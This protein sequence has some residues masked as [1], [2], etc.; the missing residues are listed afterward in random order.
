MGQLARDERVSAA[1][2]SALRRSGLSLPEKLR[3]LNWPIVALLALIGAVGY[4]MLYSAAGGSLAPWAW[5]HAVRLAVLLPTMVLAALID[6]RVW[7]RA[8]WPFYVAVLAMLVAVDVLGEINKGAQ[9]WLDLGPVQLQPSELMKVALI[10]VL[11]RYFHAVYPEDM[12]RLRVLLPAVGLILTPCALVLVQPDLGTAATLLVSG[13]AMLFLAGVRWW[14]F[15][16]VGTVG[17]AALPV[18]WA[19]L[20]DYQRQ[21]VFTFLDPD[22]DPLG[23]GYHIIQSKIA[24]GSGGMWGRGFLNGS[25]A[26]L[27]FLPEKHT[28]FAFTMLAEELGFVGA[29]SVLALFLALLLLGM[30]AAIRAPS[31]FGRLLAAGVVINLF[32]YIAINVS[33][34]TGLIPVVGVPLPLISYG[35]TALLTVLVSLGLLLSVDLHHH[36]AIP[37]YPVE[38]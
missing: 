14:K 17:A 27:S 8:A 5:R 7:F 30:V 16:A 38:P 13:T 31:Q 22:S 3:A 6:P 1:L 33:M 29:I 28:D 26:Q 15:A 4:A 35:G 11:A 12:R 32:I 24:L 18:L 9:R 10:L 19:N 20:H 34:V 25:Q 36:V 21:R 23:S 37:R 2:G